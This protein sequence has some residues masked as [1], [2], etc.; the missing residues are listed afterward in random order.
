MADADEIAED[1]VAVAR[2][3]DPAHRLRQ[4]LVEAEDRPE[5]VLGREVGAA[6]AAGVGHADA[7][8][9]ASERLALVDADAKAELGELL[10]R[11]EPGDSAAEN[12]DR[13][14]P[15]RSGETR[16]QGESK[17]AGGGVAEKSSASYWHFANNYCTNANK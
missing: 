2:E 15:R 11:G 14:R 7:A 13:R 16:R 17:P 4:V 1:P 9:L 6:A 5:P 10:S 12:G 8:R 3:R